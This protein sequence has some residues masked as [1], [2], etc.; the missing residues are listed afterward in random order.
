MKTI[1]KTI[2]TVGIKNNNNNNNSRNK[3]KE[4]FMKGSEE[5]EEKVLGYT[6]L[7]VSCQSISLIFC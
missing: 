5:V 2:T 6:S 7:F 4:E 1:I 3:D